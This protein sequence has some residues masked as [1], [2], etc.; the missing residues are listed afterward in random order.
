VPVR[1]D[2]PLTVRETERD[3]ARLD[4]LAERHAIDSPVRRLREALGA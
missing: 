4:G 2:L 1:R 3:D